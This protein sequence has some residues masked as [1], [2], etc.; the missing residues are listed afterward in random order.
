MNADLDELVDYL[1]INSSLTLA[2]S[3]RVVA[4]VVVFFA[5][6]AETFVKR[7]HLELKQIGHKNAAIYALIQEELA[8]R[9]FSAPALSTRQIRRVIYG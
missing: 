7:R 4:E 9:C 6:T 1:S 2:E 5:E 8:G 3:K